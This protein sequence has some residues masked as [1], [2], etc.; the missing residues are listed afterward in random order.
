M[1]CDVFLACAGITP[2]IGLAKDAGL[3]SNRGVVVDD[4]MR[5]ADHSIFAAGDIAEFEGRVSG[6]WPSAVEQAEVAAINAVGGDA[7]YGIT[8]QETM[9]KV[10]GIHLT[11]IGRFEPRSRDEVV[12]AKLND[13]KHTYR[14]IVIADG[15][16]VG[17]IMIGHPMS[18]P[19]VVSAV[20]QKR[21][22]SGDIDVLK[23]GDWSCLAWPATRGERQA[24]QKVPLPA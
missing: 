7:R 6:L 9:L 12:I 24:K 10:A 15:C 18:A 4:H 22:V 2:N 11:S 13:V 23:A 1:R 14:K 17:A 19:V 8:A 5:T 3:A 20:K 16:I 21:N